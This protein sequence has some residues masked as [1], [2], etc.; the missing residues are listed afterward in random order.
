MLSYSPSLSMGLLDVASRIGLTAV[1]TQLNGTFGAFDSL[2]SRVGTLREAGLDSTEFEGL[3]RRIGRHE[4]FS[5]TEGLEI[6]LRTEGRVLGA[7]TRRHSF[8]TQETQELQ[9][10]V[11]GT[12]DISPVRLLDTHRWIRGEFLR[13][14]LEG[15]DVPPTAVRQTPLIPFTALADRIGRPAFVKIEAAQSAGSFR[16]RGTTA[17]L[18][19]ALMSGVNPR[20]TGV[21]AAASASDAAGIVLAARDMGFEDVE[22]VLPNSVPES[23]VGPLRNFGVRITRFGNR[24]E[25]AENAV[26]VVRR[27]KAGTLVVPRVE[28]PMVVMGF[29]TVGVEI[30]VQ[31]TRE[32]SFHEYAVVVPTGSGDLL[33]GMAAYFAQRGISVFGAQ[34]EAYPVLAR[35]YRRREV[36]PEQPSDAPVTIAGEIAVR[37]VSRRLFPGILRQVR[38]VVTVPDHQIA[39]AVQFMRG[40]DIPSDGA[41]GAPVAAL[42]FGALR[43]EDHDLPPRLPVV[44]VVTG[45]DLDDDLLNL[46]LAQDPDLVP[47]QPAPPDRRDE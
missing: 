24:L 4:T 28:N 13:G 7:L 42:L 41:S 37:R 26:E 9:A 2:R 39:R 30:D 32:H 19:A 20:T 14:F 23:K 15:S 25:E 47:T 38:D 5:E 3:L 18:A 29:G 21:V 1:N 31:M 10:L 22:I 33:A 43:L 17:F 46:I 36:L 40:A 27:G 34:S 6:A 8:P 35:S 11:R 44:V 45:R 16:I 12:S